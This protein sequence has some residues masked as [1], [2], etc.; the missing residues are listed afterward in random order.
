MKLIFFF[1]ILGKKIRIFK[2]ELSPPNFHYDVL[3]PLY[4]G[5]LLNWLHTFVWM[6]AN[7]KYLLQLRHSKEICSYFRRNSPKKTGVHCT[8]VHTS[9]ALWPK[10]IS[11]LSVTVGTLKILQIAY[12]TPLMYC[13]GPVRGL[14]KC[15]KECKWV[16]N[17]L[18][19]IEFINLQPL[20]IRSTKSF[21]LL[22][23]IYDT[24]MKNCAT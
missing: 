24:Y 13:W 5:C 17:W 19:F 22:W 20:N 11:F 3:Y 21:P 18:P 15:V 10:F 14:V 8:V 1:L 2:P 12:T 6:G 7:W 23:L 4:S 16:I 9:M